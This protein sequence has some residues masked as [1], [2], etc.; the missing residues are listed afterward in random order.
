MK[1]INCTKTIQ[2]SR[3][4]FVLGIILSVFGDPKLKCGKQQKHADRFEF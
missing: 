4:G 2:F 1:V 3:K